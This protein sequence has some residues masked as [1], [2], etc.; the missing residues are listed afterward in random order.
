MTSVPL[1]ERIGDALDAKCL[2]HLHQQVAEAPVLPLYQKLGSG[3]VPVNVPM[4]A[5]APEHGRAVA[6]AWLEVGANAPKPE[7][8]A[9]PVS[10]TPETSPESPTTSIE[11]SQKVPHIS[12][13]YSRRM[14]SAGFERSTVRRPCSMA[15]GGRLL[16][17]RSW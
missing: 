1:K 6:I 7:Y 9:D 14:R 11:R 5:L 13:R 17:K 15:S 10:R 12:A 4:E 8:P 3:G 2:E 16:G